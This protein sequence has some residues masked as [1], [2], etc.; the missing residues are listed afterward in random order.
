[1]SETVSFRH[2]RVKKFLK[3]NSI[4]VLSR[5][6]RPVDFTINQKIAFCRAPDPFLKMV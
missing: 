1:M 4:V 2:G 3:I 6:Y 5:I